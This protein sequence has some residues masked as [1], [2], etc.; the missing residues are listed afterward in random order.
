MVTG[1]AEQK[2]AVAAEQSGKSSEKEQLNQTSKAKETASSKGSEGGGKAPETFTK[3][4]IEKARSEAKSE[5]SKLAKAEFDKKTSPLYEQ[6]K[7]LE[8]QLAE[9]KETMEDL[10]TE[11]KL[12]AD[13]DKEREAWGENSEVKSFQEARRNLGKI[14]KELRKRVDGFNKQCTALINDV[15]L[16]SARTEAITA[17]LPEV[18]NVISGF[19]EEL[20]KEADSPKAMRYLAKLKG[21]EYRAKLLESLKVEGKKE[22]KAPEPEE[23]RRPDSSSH[24]APGGVDVSKLSPDQKLQ[25]G[26][27][28]EKQKKK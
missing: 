23:Q 14:D 26:F 1:T 5:A 9:L 24:S 22:E 13:E 15:Q 11:G 27:R 3:E 16:A 6:N 8:S 20:V 4:D 17:I 7:N 19:V 21:S 12:K 10:Q 18:E 28:R 25:E 2:P